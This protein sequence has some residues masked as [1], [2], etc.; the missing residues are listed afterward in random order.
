RAELRD[1]LLPADIAIVVVDAP[2]PTLGDVTS[3]SRVLVDREHA[4][5][6]IWWIAGSA[7]STLVTYDRGVDRVLVRTVAFATPLDAAQSAEAARMARTMLRALRVT[8][9]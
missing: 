5:G 3:A 9:D 1:A 2:T 6:A 7:G 4:T 8:P